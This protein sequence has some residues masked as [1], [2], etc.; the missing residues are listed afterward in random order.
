M[1]LFDWVAR[2][3]RSLLV[4]LVLAGAGFYLGNVA[5]YVEQPLRIEENEWPA[6]AKGTYD[7]G[8]PLIKAGDDHRI[9]FNPDGTVE[10]EDYIGLW[11]PPLYMHTMA[12]F[13]VVA[14]D[15]ATT[16]LRL[17]GAFG[18]LA[19]CV[20]L[21]LIAREVTP[22]RNA[23]RLGA[24][25]SFLLLIHPYAVQG[26]LFLDIDTS[27]YPA[28]FLF[29]FWQVARF[30]RREEYSVR[31]GL[32]LG[33][34]LALVLWCKLTTVLILLP[35]LLLFW[36]IRAGVRRGLPHALLV[37]GS[38][39]LIFFATYGLY[40]LVTDQPFWYTFNF[41]FGKTNG[42]VV[43]KQASTKPLEFSLKLQA[44]WFI[45]AL[46]LMT[47]V[48][49]WTALWRWISE[50]RVTM[51]DLIWLSG[52]AIFVMYAAIVPNGSIYES[53]YALPA[54]PMIVFSVT[55]MLLGVNRPPGEESTG[56]EPATKLWP[57]AALTGLTIL[58]T[59]LAVAFMP[60]LITRQGFIRMDSS[61]RVWIFIASAVGLLVLGCLPR[62]RRYAPAAIL[63]LLAALF[64]VQSVKSYRA[65]VSPL[66]PG[67]DTAD[68]IRSGEIINKELRPREVAIVSKDLGI[69]IKERVIEGEDIWLV[70]GDEFEAGAIS[71]NPW[72]TVLATNA[73]GPPFDDYTQQVRDSCFDKQQVGR[74]AVYVRKPK[75][76]REPLK[77]SE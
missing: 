77:D 63:T 7:N 47:A 65:N 54:L 29:F 70:R 14:G 24:V 10:Q 69:R 32:V 3:E 22:G 52:A 66:F 20:L 42:L 31:A 40:V 46:L 28:A 50:R 8:K 23:F 9:K 41:T 19:C 62:M 43:W 5:H 56:K 1:S 48:Y 76:G 49:G 39:A 53:K 11:H 26:S 68:F 51:T 61:G 4:L 36:V 6:M 71:G 58:A 55:A 45:P 37:I 67:I 15:D 2:H 38:G 34:A 74:A 59:L 35:I 25:A 16:S 21:F 75:C 44:S 12:A 17:I 57:I 30:E 27:I 60:D 33:A 18:L 64:L 72:I 13:M 73:F